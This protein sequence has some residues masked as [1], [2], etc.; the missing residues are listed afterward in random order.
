MIRHIAAL[1]LA[2]S[3]ALAANGPLLT[4]I[5]PDA[6]VVG[7]IH[8]DRTLSSAF[9]RF[10]ISQMNDSSSDFNRFIEATGFDPRRDL[11]EM[12]FASADTS[13]KSGV[14]IARGVFNGPQIVAYARSHGGTVSS[15]NGVEIVSAKD[16]RQ[17]VAIFDGDTAVAGDDRF[18]RYAIDQRNATAAATAP[19]FAKAAN[20]RSRYDGWVIAAGIFTPGI[21]GARTPVPPAA[22]MQGIE[23]TSGGV[24][25]GTVVRVTGEAITRSDKDAQALVDVM[26]FVIGMA[27]GAA[28]SNPE[29]KLLE[30]L[31]TN[32]NLRAEASV[33]KLSLSIPEADLEQL[34]KSTR[35]ARTQR[36]A[37]R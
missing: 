33:V 1:T 32:L 7:G 30:P 22:V 3:A 5:P 31:F 12:V 18:V 10:V 28:S 16:G 11:R 9:G 15:Y 26:R 36:A 8:V 23:E 29:A 14:V 24:E 19:L 17:T 37:A 6:K 34:M 21:P 35:G 20:L 27:Q 2:A 13:R 25:F 4:F